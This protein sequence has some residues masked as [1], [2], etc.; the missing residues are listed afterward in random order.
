MLVAYGDF[1]IVE[2]VDEEMSSTIIVPDKAKNYSVRGK[3]VSVGPGP[4]GR[5]GQYHPLRVAVGEVIYF[6]KF[7]VNEIE[8]ERAKYK[9]V[10]ERD[11]LAVVHLNKKEKR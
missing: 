3:V 5:D 11:I 1:V 9:I 10:A 4:R 6:A 2:P 7:S 8:H